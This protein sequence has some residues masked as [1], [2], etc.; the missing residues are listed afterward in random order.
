[1]NINAIYVNNYTYFSQSVKPYIS[2]KLHKYRP[3]LLYIYTK[4]AVHAENHSFTSLSVQSI[5]LAVKPHPPPAAVPLPRE[6]KV[7]KETVFK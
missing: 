1:M 6:G 2:T 5:L 7:H 3:L 4:E